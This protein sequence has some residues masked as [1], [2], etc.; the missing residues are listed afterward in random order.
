M[1]VVV[2]YNP[3]FDKSLV[4]LHDM[5]E[6]KLHVDLIMCMAIAGISVIFSMRLF[7]M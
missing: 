7:V 1:S 3:N 2:Q 5:P 6:K 4:K